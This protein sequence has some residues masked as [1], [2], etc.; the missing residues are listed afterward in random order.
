MSEYFFVVINEESSNLAYNELITPK[1]LLW[2][3]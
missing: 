1:G 3:R 2:N